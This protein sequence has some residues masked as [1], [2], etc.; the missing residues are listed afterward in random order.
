MRVATINDDVAALEEG[1]QGLDPIIDSLARLDKKH[2]AAGLLQ[3]RDELLGRVGADDG[4]ALGLVGEESIDLGDG[5]VE[6]A[7]GEAMVGHVQDQILAP[8]YIV[9]FV[10]GRGKE[11]AYMTARPMRPRSA[12]APS[13]ALLMVC[14]VTREPAFTAPPT[15]RFARRALEALSRCKRQTP[16]S[17]SLSPLS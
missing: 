6:S 12:L 5:A 4:L 3:L 14:E 13:L 17:P 9:N 11:R 10:H 1:E 8:C 7:N 2:D 16:S 15:L